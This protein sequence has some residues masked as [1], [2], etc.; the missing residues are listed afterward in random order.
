MKRT[1][2]LMLATV[3]AA[4]L[5]VLGGCASTA[6]DGN[7]REVRQ[8]GIDRLGAETRW[9]ASDAE[10]EDM[11]KAVDR[12]LDE[13]LSLESA[14]RI[15]L[16]YSPAFQVVL[17]EAAAESADATQSARI[18][19]PV[20]TFEHLVR[21]ADGERALDIGR[22][23][24]V[25]LLDIL[26][27]PARLERAEFRQQ[28]LRLRASAELVGK[29]GEVRQAW[30]GAVAAR[31]VADYRAQALEVAEAGAELARR[32]QLVGNFSRLERAR[33]Q[34]AYANAAA[35]LARARQQALAAREHLIRVLGL[36]GDQT[37]RLVLPAHLPPLP[38]SIAAEDAFAR[39]AFD[40]RL[41]VRMAR[42][43]LDWTAKSLGLTRVTS[44]VNGL[45]LAA[46]HNSET[47]EAEQRGYEIELPLPIFD[48]GDAR[49]AGAQAR[50]MAALNATAQ[51]AA[52]AASELR[53][54]YSGYRSA[55]A[56]A[57][58]YREELV[59]L[60]ESISEEL[61]LQ[62]NGMLTGVFELLADAR[63]RVAVVAAA[64]EAERDAWLAHVALRGAM[65]GRPARL[66]A[67]QAAAA[68]P[69]PGGGH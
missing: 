22:S 55:W 69:E 60:R 16:G 65:L 37:Q 50:Y 9:L 29:L 34:V 53:E 23:L 20:F 26:L 41:D 58:H 30:V 19:N 43:E 59:P 7:Y 66:P 2:R 15:A 57:R 49:R 32:M 40:E 6:I 27:L 54:A 10:R 44:V 31:Q 28:Q 56:L 48:F 46:V 3:S 64:I 4:L 12:M 45:H 18:A 36:A 5:L 52:V 11:A 1:P 61:L 8:Y 47:G 13:A 38:T 35:D 21:S 24:G 14:E 63:V 42:A 51:A 17:A 39:K 62:Y 67:M 33:E 68:A 25:S